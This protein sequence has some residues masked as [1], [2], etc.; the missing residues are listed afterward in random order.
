MSKLK[1]KDYLTKKLGIKLKRYDLKEFEKYNIDTGSVIR[2]FCRLTNNT[3]TVAYELLS[4]EMILE[5]V[6]SINYTSV[7]S[8]ILCNSFNYKPLEFK[9]YITLGEFF[10]RYI[11]GS[12]RLAIAVQTKEGCHIFPII[13]NTWYDEDE[14]LNIADEF[15]AGYILYIIVDSVSYNKFYKFLLRDGKIE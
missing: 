2:T 11:S 8:N 4:D 7:I 5:K 9:N 15:L 12:S 6:E 14:I 1:R 10:D 13:N 3:F